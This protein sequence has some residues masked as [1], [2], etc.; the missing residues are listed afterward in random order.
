MKIL[1]KDIVNLLKIQNI[2]AFFWGWNLAGRRGLTKFVAM[3]GVQ[4][5][6]LDYY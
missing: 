1:N 3:Y 2:F 4:H 6:P 5:Y